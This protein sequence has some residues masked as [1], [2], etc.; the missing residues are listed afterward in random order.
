[1]TVTIQVR[2]GEKQKKRLEAMALSTGTS[3]TKLLNALVD[4][5]ADVNGIE[6][7][8]QINFKIDQEFERR[9]KKF[10]TLKEVNHD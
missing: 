7:T 2:L 10:P 4:L 5:A 9:V 1:M 8:E 3:Q 6:I